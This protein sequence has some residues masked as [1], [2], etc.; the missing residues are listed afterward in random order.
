MIITYKGRTPVVPANVFIAPGAYVIGDVEIGAES[1][2]WFNAVIRGDVNSIRIGERTSIQDMCMVH[3]TKYV[4]PTFIGS[5]VTVGHHVV[6]HGC[7]IGNYCLIGM[8]S[9][10]LDD[11]DIGERSII[12]AGTILAPGTKV[13]PRSMVMGVPGKVKREVNERELAMLE[14]SAKAYVELASDYLAMPR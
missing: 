13:P 4:Y 8:G 6:M 3:A 5:D 1:S 14:T 7:K 2:V 10:I 11:C 9:V 12:G